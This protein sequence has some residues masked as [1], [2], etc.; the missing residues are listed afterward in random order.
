MNEQILVVNEN[1]ETIGLNT[2]ENCHLGNGI[3]HRAITIFIFNNKKE[4]LLARRSLLKKL[5][6][7]FWDTSCSAHVRQKETYE[8][9]GK[10]RLNDELGFSCQLKFLFKFQY[11]ASFQSIGSENEICA[12]LAGDYTGSINPNPKEVLDYKWISIEQ[13]KNEINNTDIS[14]W[15]KIAFGKYLEYSKHS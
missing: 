10:R 1:D 2:K 3:L 14:P 15:L 13:L 7:N 5:W 9:A 4:I 12:L 8:Q 11:Q 6:P